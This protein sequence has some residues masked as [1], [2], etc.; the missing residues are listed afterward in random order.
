MLA[1]SRKAIINTVSKA[2]YTTAATANALQFTTAANGVKVAS[3]QEPGQAVSLAVVINGGSRAE[4]GKNAGVAHYLKNYGFKNN[5][6]RTAFRISREAELAG[7]VL[8]SN[9][10]HETL[11]YSAEFLKDDVELFAELLGDVVSKQKYQEHEFIDV[12]NQTIGE[13][14][15]A[16]ADSEVRAIEVA[17]Q[18][19]FRTGLGNSIFAKPTS[20]VNNA[21]VKAFAQELF[22]KGNIALVGTGIDHEYLQTLA[23]TYFNLPLGQLSLPA[24][25]YYGGDSRVESGSKNN[26]YVV[27][28]EGAALNTSEY[29]ALQVLRYALGGD[30]NIKNTE[31][32][33]LL[34]QAAMK[35]TEGTHM[36][37]FNM[38]YS[39]AGLFGIQVTSDSA[40]NTGVAI[41]AAVEQLKAA[42]KNLSGDNFNKALAQAKYATT[43]GF[44]TR[45]DRLE[46]LG[47][48]ALYS[49]KNISASEYAAAVSK[50]S[51]SDVA[52]VAEKLSKSKPTTVALGDLSN[53][54]YAD[55]ISL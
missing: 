41:A 24:T 28:Y 17:H 23:E 7:G 14:A 21:A 48:Q 54:P 34:S 5:T 52:K 9:L 20:H 43:A 18:T 11:V 38:G 36:K 32:S 16:Y 37:A 13:S 1:A 15:N 42:T 30:V 50:V 3:S 27:A 12:A 6:N 22:T 44:Q 31:G 4:S 33:G 29:A 8:S 49:G 39:D 46:T 19:A 45:L 25:Q 55:S 35:F 53:L 10:S 26:Q 51:A 40:T 47:A 2:T